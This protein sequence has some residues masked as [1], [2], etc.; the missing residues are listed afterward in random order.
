MCTRMY[1]SCPIYQ[2]RLAAAVSVL[3]SLCLACACA[4]APPSYVC[5]RTHAWPRRASVCVETQT[6]GGKPVSSGAPQRR[7]QPFYSNPGGKRRGLVQELAKLGRC[8][9]HAGWSSS[10]GLWPGRPSDVASARCPAGP[11]PR[12]TYA[13]IGSSGVTGERSSAACTCATGRRV[14]ETG[15]ET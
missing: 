6:K 3:P 12:R 13:R 5:I 7:E 4:C 11:G 1:T 15:E 10:D 14:R 8:S 2:H 9:F